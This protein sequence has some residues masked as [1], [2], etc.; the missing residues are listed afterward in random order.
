MEQVYADAIVNAQVA[1]LFSKVMFGTTTQTPEGIRNDTSF[2]VIIPTDS[3]LTAAQQ[4]I[5][6]YTNNIDNIER[7]TKVILEAKLAAIQQTKVNLTAKESVATEESNVE[8]P[9]KKSWREA[10]IK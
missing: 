7:D 5:Q 1:P 9:N 4:I 3:L 10:L 2:T 6:L 8:N